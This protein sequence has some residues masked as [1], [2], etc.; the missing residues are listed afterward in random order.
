MSRQQ[1]ELLKKSSIVENAPYLFTDPFSEAP[2]GTTAKCASPM[3]ASFA[4]C[5]TP[6]PFAKCGSVDSF[7]GCTPG[8]AFAKCGGGAPFAKCDPPPPAPFAKC[9]PPPFAK[10]DL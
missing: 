10:C 1:S 7:A 4:T 5:T 9:D 3:N 8:A 2:V 6:A